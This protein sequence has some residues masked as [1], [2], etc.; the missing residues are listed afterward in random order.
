MPFVLTFDA[1][2]RSGGPP[3]RRRSSAE[4]DDGGSCQAR[5]G[6]GDTS[7]ETSDEAQAGWVGQLSSAAPRLALLHRLLDLNG[8]RRLAEGFQGGLAHL[9]G[10][11]SAPMSAQCRQGSAQIATGEGNGAEASAEHKARRRQRSMQAY[12]LRSL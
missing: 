3:L 9:I 5:S 6:S 2:V 8:A 4:Y 12:G 10:F 7:T 11:L 1:G